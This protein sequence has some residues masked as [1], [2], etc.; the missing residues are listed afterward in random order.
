M[1]DW[2]EILQ[3]AGFPT[4]AVVLDFETYFDKDYTL[5][6]LSAIEYIKDERFELSGLGF[7]MVGG[8]PAFLHPDEKP[9]HLSIAHELESLRLW[10][11][12]NL[13]RVTVVVQNGK[14]DCLILQERF[15]IT[16]K[17]TVDLMDLDKMWD[18][19][20][21]H[22][23]ADMAEK[24]HAPVLK[25][26]TM[27]FKGLHWNTMSPTK[28]IALKQYTLKDIEI[29]AWLFKRMM[30]VVVSR[31]EVELSVANETLQM[32]LRHGF[33]IDVDLGNKIVI[34]MNKEMAGPVAEL[35]ILGITWT[36]KPTRKNPVPVP[37]PVQ[38]DDISK[39][40]RFA[41]LIESAGGSMP[42]KKGKNKMIPALAK[43]DEGTK[44]LLA[45]PNPKVRA[46]AAARQAVQ[47]WPLHIAKVDHILAQARAWGGRIG[48]PLGYHNAHTGR[49]GGG[50]K[51]N[52]QN[53]GGRGR[54]GK[55]THPLIQ[56]VRHM[57]RAPKGFLLGIQDY[58][59]IEAVC[60]AWL[61]H[62]DDLTEG[63]RN[64]SDVYSDLASELFGFPVRKK[65]KTDPK[66]VAAR[67]E[68]CRG[69]GKDAILGCGYGMGADK[70]YKR[71]YSN[72]DLRPKFDD[73]TF[74]HEFI[75]RVI[76]TY[77]T[78]Y[79]CIPEFWN[80]LEKSWR[81]VTKYPNERV[82]LDTCDLEF[83]HADGATFVRL[84]SG[85][86]Q[87]YPHAKV[88]SRGREIS[89]HWGPLWGGTLTENIDSAICRDL[90]AESILRL[91]DNGFQ[92]VLTVH[93]EIVCLLPEKDAEAR[94]KEMGQI[95]SV[96]PS[97]ATGFPISVE[98]DL[99]EYYKK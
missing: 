31:P 52:L 64:G 36:D 3:R 90:I 30:P 6:N 89:Y 61:A 11:G 14:F 59:K 79:K 55:G 54:G 96:V 4:E 40:S 15:G 74:D 17:F 87:R 19:R 16:P 97:W 5:K 21:T 83:W 84:P 24:W 48:T 80:T 29:E 81:W 13:E 91:M 37:R 92:I 22:N 82:Q 41:V 10:A 99:S 46:L 38:A 77:H 35:G 68:V 56:E 75:A 65:R 34:G 69:L 1:T 33:E 58:S 93:D 49:W 66:Q 78:K 32:F 60:L 18:A 26:D 51:I 53:L 47:S 43:D 25:G 88:S 73:G 12:D 86:T 9:L 62:Q 8:E 28:R 70:F 23:L 76:K 20:A 50:E 98:G 27:E 42:M 57:L 85:R 2:Q 45:D 7:A 95:M 72:E 39:D 94:H 71:C 63:F 44:Q 67:L